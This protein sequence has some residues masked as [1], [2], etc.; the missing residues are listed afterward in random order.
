M[1]AGRDVGVKW[2]RAENWWRSSGEG[3]RRRVFMRH[4]I[5]PELTPLDGLRY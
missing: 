2:I 1:R 3:E 4:V 5:G